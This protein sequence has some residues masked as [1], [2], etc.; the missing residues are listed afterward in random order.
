MHSRFNARLK[1]I[2]KELNINQ[3]ENPIYFIDDIS[4]PQRV[5]ALVNGKHYDLTQE[6]WEQQ[7]NKLK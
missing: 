4:E 2:E 5:F 3:K 7:K 1:R 6:E